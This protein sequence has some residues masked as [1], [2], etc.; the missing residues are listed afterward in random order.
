VF[1]DFAKEYPNGAPANT[2]NLTFFFYEISRAS[3]RKISNPC[4][5][6]ASLVA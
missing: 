2:R 3:F 5:S 6:F 4:S 1:K